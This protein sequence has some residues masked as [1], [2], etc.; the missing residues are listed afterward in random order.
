MQQKEKDKVKSHELSIGEY[1]GDCDCEGEGG[2][3][4]SDVARKRGAP[5]GASPED[6]KKKNF[7]DKRAA[8]YNEV[9][10]RVCV[11]VCIFLYFC[12][13]VC[14]CVYTSRCCVITYDALFLSLVISFWC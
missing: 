4:S 1:T 12:V 3:D 2:R 13:C 10:L 5:S 11:Y 9:C 14:V 7:A 6:S 8:H